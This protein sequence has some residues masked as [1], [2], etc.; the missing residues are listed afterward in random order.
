MHIYIYTYIIFS[1]QRLALPP[2]SQHPESQGLEDHFPFKQRCSVGWREC[3]SHGE[4]K[5]DGLPKQHNMAVSQKF[6]DPFDHL[7]IVV[8]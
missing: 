3:T 8:C 5:M 7:E 1:S 6:R 4:S 2:K